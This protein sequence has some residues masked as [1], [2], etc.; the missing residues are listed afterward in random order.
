MWVLSD[1][2]QAPSGAGYALETRI[3]MSR[4]MAADFRANMV[5]RLS[6]YFRSMRATLATMAP[7]HKDD[8][9]I[10]LLTPGPLNE[11]YFEHAYLASYLGYTLVQG[12]D[13][14]VRGEGK[15]WLKSIDG[16]KQVDI[17][18]RRMDDSFCDPLELREDSY[19]GIPGL[20]QAARDGQV[21][22]VNPLGSG[23]IES[24]GLYPFLSGI[25]KQW[26]GE[27]LKM[28]CAATWW[29]GHDK[30]RDHVIA[31]IEQFVV[32]SID[33]R[34]KTRFGGQL[35]LKERE[36]LIAQIK[37][38]PYLFVGQERITCSSTPSLSD[39]EIVPRRV[40]L[41]SFLVANED[42]Y[43]AMPGGLTRIASDQDDFLISNQAGGASKDTWIITDT[44]DR[45]RSLL[46][47]YSDLMKQLETDTMLPSRSAENLYW[48]GR[49]AERSEGLIRLLRTA[50]RKMSDYD[51]YQDEVDKA[52]LNRLLSA[53]GD[54]SEIKFPDLEQE[55]DQSSRLPSTTIL[56]VAFNR[57]EPGSMLSNLN[58]L[59]YGAFNVRDLWSTDTWR[60]L[61]DIGELINDTK[62]SR[63]SVAALDKQID[64]LIDILMAFSGL[65]AE[66]MSHETGWFMLDL[67][68]RLERA[69][70]LVKFVRSLLVDYDSQMDEQLNI[71]SMMASQES[72]MTYRRRYR[73]SSSAAAAIYLLVLDEHHPRSL[74]YQIK[75]AI[76]LS[77]FTET[78]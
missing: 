25:A 75:T 33:R 6:H 54:L 64:R 67:G 38:R 32:K 73:L 74:A 31:N 22:I 77:A 26:L 53:L 63:R 59:F 76:A 47:D 55:K 17:I 7:S 57:D 39:G 21:T 66:S 19:L 4:V 37:A 12:A 9:N 34:F 1:R 8:P 10:V 78:I 40:L 3:S 61:D 5:R 29:C 2:T 60:I 68:K 42:G 16:L 13:L 15:V 48:V 14:T 23:I 41:R 36:E 71:E 70:Q 49:Y 30:E 43:T 18:L 45:Q 20:V 27:D 11:T 28:D 46:A 51:E 56:D 65:T 44:P 72:L 24:P 52:C 50:L 62:S 58:S 69:L 35:S